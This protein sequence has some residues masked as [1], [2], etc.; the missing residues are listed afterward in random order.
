VRGEGGVRVGADVDGAIIVII[1]EK[2]DPLGSGELLFQ[3]TNDGFL[4]L[5]L[6]SEGD[7]ALTCLCLVQDRRRASFISYSKHE[8]RRGH[9]SGDPSYHGSPGKFQKLKTHF[10]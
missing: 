8:E 4:L 3:V 5:L 10:E 7:G 2:C 6:P 9:S 1:L